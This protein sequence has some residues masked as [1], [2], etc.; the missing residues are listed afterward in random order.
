MRLKAEPCLIWGPE[1]SVGVEAFDAEHQQ[2][3]ELINRYQEACILCCRNTDLNTGSL[4][5]K[6]V[7]KIFYG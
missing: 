5:R 3:F 7:Q 4:K 6:S 2:L 1:F